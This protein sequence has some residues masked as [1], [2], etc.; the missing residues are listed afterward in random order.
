MIWSD[1]NHPDRFYGA[2][3]TK[4]GGWL[5]V[6]VNEGTSS[7]NALLI[8]GPHDDELRWLIST[9]DASVELIGGIGDKLWFKTDRNA[10]HGKIVSV[11]LGEETPTWE[12]IIPEQQNILR[13]ADI[14]G[15]KIAATWLEDASSKATMHSL[16]GN[17]LYTVDLPDIGTVSGFGGQNDDTNIFYSYSSFNQPPSIYT[18]DLDSGKTLRFW[19]TD[20]PID[21]SNVVVHR[22]FVKSN[23]WHISSSFYHCT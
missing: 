15:G 17:E 8:K 6:S 9:F 19:Q 3:V 5:V 23:R 22:K 4:D 1:K 11:N 10:P 14:V 16:E 20:F 12:E 2:L 7:N 21:L 13:S 18:L